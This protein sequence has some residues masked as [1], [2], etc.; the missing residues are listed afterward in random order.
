MIETQLEVWTP[1]PGEFLSEV[2][3]LHKLSLT[4]SYELVKQ[5][6]FDGMVVIFLR[7]S[8]VWIGTLESVAAHL[9][10]RHERSQHKHLYDMRRYPNDSPYDMGAQDVEID[11]WGFITSAYPRQYIVIDRNLPRA[12]QENSRHEALAN[13][14]QSVQQALDE[15]SAIPEKEQRLEDRKAI[16][17]NKGYLE[18][19]RQLFPH[20]YGRDGCFG[21]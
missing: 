3:R 2:A 18:R 7:L 14:I 4:E 17:H 8:E 11:V 6:R 21:M 19:A 1:R 12:V 9:G 5:S 20:F 13:R 15:L 10:L 16:A